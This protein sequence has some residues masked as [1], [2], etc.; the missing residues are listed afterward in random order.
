MAEIAQLRK[1]TGDPL[2]VNS[3]KVFRLDD[4]FAL[5]TEFLR[6]EGP[7]PAALAVNVPTHQRHLKQ[8]S[9]SSIR[10]ELSSQFY[11]TSKT[12]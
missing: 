7:E 10:V 9:R 12:G 2:Q 8:T 4:H 6:S 1:D 5:R 3:S 11:Q